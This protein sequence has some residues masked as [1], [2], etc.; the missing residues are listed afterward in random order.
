MALLF[1]IWGLL[2]LIGILKLVIFPKEFLI[3]HSCHVIFPFL[4]E[5]FQKRRAYNF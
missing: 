4:P 3:L 5:H 1:L 2:L